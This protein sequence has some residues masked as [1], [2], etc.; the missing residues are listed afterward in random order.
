LRHH[1]ELPLAGLPADERREVLEYFDPEKKYHFNHGTSLRLATMFGG[2]T[3]KILKA[4]ELLF[5]VPGSPIIYYGDEI[6]M[7]NRALNVNE[8]DTRRSVR[9]KFDWE[10]AERQMNDPKSLFNG[11]VEIVKRAKEAAL[12]PTTGAEVAAPSSIA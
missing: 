11:V 10:K 9:G 2:D 5:S 7:E 12:A 3:Q 6:G 4:Y 1:D 8:R